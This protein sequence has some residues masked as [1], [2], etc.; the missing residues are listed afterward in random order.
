MFSTPNRSLRG[1]AIACCPV[2]FPASLAAPAISSE[3]SKRTAEH[4][5]RERQEPIP[6]FHRPP[7]LIPRPEGRGFCFCGNCEPS[8]PFAFNSLRS[9]FRAPN[10]QPSHIHALA[11]SLLD[12]QKITA[13]LSVTSALV[14]Y[15][16]A[17]ER[18]ATAALSYTCEL[19]RKNIGVTLKTAK[20]VLEVTR[21]AAPTRAPL[22]GRSRK[23]QKSQPQS[24][25]AAGRDEV[26]FCS[27]HL[28][29][30]LA[31]RPEPLPARQATA[32]AAA[33]PGNAN[34]R[35]GVVASPLNSHHLSTV[36]SNP[37]P[38]APTLLATPALRSSILV[39]VG[40]SLP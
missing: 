2:L 25:A 38:A 30:V 26:P 5:T 32:R 37:P 7:V 9:L 28:R 39:S 3:V 13:A 6:I 24:C 40:R 12:A 23:N 10:L 36:F 11:H 19:F 31:A 33:L 16:R 27:S 8:A 34:L 1:R 14:A 22:I 35:I 18:K 17:P 21:L 15:S 4:P 29:G 20:V